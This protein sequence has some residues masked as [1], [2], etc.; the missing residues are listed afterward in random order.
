MATAPYLLPIEDYLH[1]RYKPDVH[2]VDGEIEERNV[3]ESPHSRIQTYIAHLFL[4]HESEWQAEPLVE[5]RIRIGSSR[6]RVCDIAIARADAPFEDVLVTPPLACI[7]VLSPEDRLPRAE[8]VLADYFAM[9]VPNIWLFD[10]LRQIAYVFDEKGLRMADPTRLSIPG[11]SI[12]ID[13]TAVF[14]KLD[15]KM[16]LA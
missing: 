13:L 16:G 2:F 3:G 4:L 5:Q 7:E 8:V 9:G 12:Q 14:N 1:T 15:Q 10:P 11:T 6:V